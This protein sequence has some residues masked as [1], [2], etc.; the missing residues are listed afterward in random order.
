MSPRRPSRTADG[1]GQA[2]A[3]PHPPLPPEDD[4]VVVGDQVA[5]ATAPAPR[6]KRPAFGSYMD[7][8][9]QRR[10]KAACVLDGIEMQDAL[11][12]AVTMW[13]TTRQQPDQQV[14]QLAG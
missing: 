3:L 4:E 13:L 14:S 10:F 2:P 11:A 5:A 12:E 6:R 1:G 8:D 9:L 7:Q